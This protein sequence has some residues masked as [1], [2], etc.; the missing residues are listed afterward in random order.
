[1]AVVLAI[2]SLLVLGTGPA[3]AAKSGQLGGISIAPKAINIGS[4]PVSACPG[5]TADCRYSVYI[6]NTAPVSMTLTSLYTDGGGF[7]FIG[8]LGYPDQCWSE[9]VLA[10]GATCVATIGFCTS[11]LCDPYY[12]PLPVGRYEGVLLASWTDGAR[13]ITVSAKL[14]ARIVAG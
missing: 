14:S 6:T 10:P 12:G 4:V 9:G 3:L 1:M 8:L 13:V 2:S 5:N 11:V 7:Y